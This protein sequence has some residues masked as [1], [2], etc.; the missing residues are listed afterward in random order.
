MIKKKVTK[1]SA[2]QLAEDFKK[3][4]DITESNTRRGGG[5]D[6][7]MLEIVRELRKSD[8]LF[9]DITNKAFSQLNMGGKLK[10]M[11]ESVDETKEFSLG[12][13]YSAHALDDIHNDLITMG[14]FTED[15]RKVFDQVHKA[16]TLEEVREVLNTSTIDLKAHIVEEF[17]NKWMEMRV[18]ADRRRVE[19]YIRLHQAIRELVNQQMNGGENAMPKEP[20]SEKRRIF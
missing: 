14:I 4:H 19:E 9:A 1:A 2:V 20:G 3:S 10:K 12:F 13:T 16:E 15:E 7:W 11:F 8:V 6:H 18:P 5:S 17:Q